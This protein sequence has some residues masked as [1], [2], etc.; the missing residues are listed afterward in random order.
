MSAQ[1]QPVAQNAINVAPLIRTFMSR[2]SR[3]V[4][5]GG[6]IGAMS[7][8]DLYLTLLYLTH[9]GMSE[10]NPLARA[11]IA[12]QSP[13]VLAVWKL[14]TVTFCVGI[15]YLIRHKRSAE[16]GAWVGAIVLGLLMTHWARYIE[17]SV[18]YKPLISTIAADVDEDWV[19]I[20]PA[21][22]G[23]MTP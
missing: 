8:I 17:E 5:L 23:S 19:F 14:L 10:A 7:M 22:V 4:I 12:Y 13:F 16:L 9:T 6:A 21:S 2:P 15:L 18:E 1:T 11:I 20:D 3:V